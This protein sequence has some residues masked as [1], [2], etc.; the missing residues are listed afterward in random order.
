MLRAVPTGQQRLGAA[1]GRD[2]DPG[3]VGSWGRADLEM[4]GGRLSSTNGGQGLAQVESGV[5]RR[6]GRSS[7]VVRGGRRHELGVVCTCP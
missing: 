4:A 1:R 7:A 6:C 2:D 3:N 5:E